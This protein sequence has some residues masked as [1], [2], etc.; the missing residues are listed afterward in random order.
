MTKR[1]TLIDSLRGFSLVGILLANLLIFQ[2]GIWGKQELDVSTLSKLDF[3]SLRFIQIA[4]EYSF[5]PIFTLLFGYSLIKLVEAIKKR[6]EKTR[7]HLVRRALGLVVIGYIHSTYIWEGDILLFYG[8]MLFMLLPFVYRKPKTLFIW[9][10]IF[11]FLTSPFGYG[12]YEQSNDDGVEMQQYIEKAN[13]VYQNGTYSEILEFSNTVMPPVFD[14][15][16]YVF[17]LI[18]LSP[19][20]MI[21]LFLIGM[22]MAKIQFFKQPTQEKRFYVIGSILIP[23]GLALKALSFNSNIEAW[24]AILLQ[25]GGQ[26]LALGYVSLF[27]L[28]YSKYSR[29]FMFSAFESVGKLSLTNYLMQSVI[30][31]FVFYGYGLG[32]FARMGVFNSIILG[33]VI[34]AVQCGLSTLYIRYFKRG[35]IEQILRMWTNFS[36]NGNVKQLSKNSADKVS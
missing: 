33:L 8:M 15:P 19:F 26:M 36:F 30:C 28:L 10:A 11:F 25:M 6:R 35:P 20:S 31:T 17:L 27:A 4:V 21:S 24:S 29:N 22:G 5:L 18:V 12:M 1:V 7:W 13:D 14:D 23:V 2:Y 9:G 32:Y 34:F 3:I 16:L